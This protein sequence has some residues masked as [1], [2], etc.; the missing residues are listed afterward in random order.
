MKGTRVGV[1]NCIVCCASR[2]CLGGE[3]AVHANLKTQGGWRSR[4][5][6]NCF[7]VGPDAGEECIEY[8]VEWILW[9]I[10]HGYGGEYRCLPCVRKG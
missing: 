9:R 2:R 10:E 6:W 3:E 4:S 8:V 7:R 5:V 1:D